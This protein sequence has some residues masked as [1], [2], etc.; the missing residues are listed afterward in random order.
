LKNFETRHFPRKNKVSSI[1]KNLI[2]SSLMPNDR[3]EKLMQASNTIMRRRNTFGYHYELGKRDTNVV[4]SFALTMQ[5][6]YP[7]RA[8]E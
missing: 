4:N 7:Q 2:D 3:G 8:A 1:V 6:M 5:E